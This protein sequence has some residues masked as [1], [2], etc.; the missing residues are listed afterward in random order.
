MNKLTKIVDIIHND[1]DSVI[2]RVKEGKRVE[3]LT[4]GC[5]SGNEEMIIVSKQTKRH[6]GVAFRIME[7][8]GNSFSFTDNTLVSSTLAAM[9]SLIK[10]TVVMDFGIPIEDLS[11]VELLKQFSYIKSLEDDLNAQHAFKISGFSKDDM[12]L[13][14][15]GAYMRHISLDNAMNYLEERYHIVSKTHSNSKS[16]GCD[17][18]TV[19]TSPKSEEK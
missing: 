3:L 13:R 10:E 9:K 16:T 18:Y 1:E 5:F 12:V 17:I 8:N 2:L 15:D 19:E 4:T 14:K 7:A 6:D 11:Y